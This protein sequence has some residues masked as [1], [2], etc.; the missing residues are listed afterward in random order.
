MKYALEI[1]N[2]AAAYFDRMDR[3]GQ[4]R[5]AEMLRLV[6]D[7]PFRQGTKKLKGFPYRSARVGDWRIVYEVLPEKLRVHVVEIGSR[8]Q[9]YRRLR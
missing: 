3:A 6:C 5:V 8:G 2:R 1:S 7:D 4:R 9:V